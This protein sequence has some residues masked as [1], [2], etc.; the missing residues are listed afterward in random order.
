LKITRVETFSIIVPVH[1]GSW[2]SPEYLPEG[3]TYGG[4]FIRLNWPEFPIVL[5]KLHTDEGLVGLGEVPKG[6]LEADVRRHAMF[7]EGRNLWS[8]NLQELPFDAMWFD[9][10]SAMCGYEMALFDLMGKALD[11]PAYR[12][13]GGKYRDLVPVSRCSGR[14]SPEHAAK[15]ANEA[16]AQGYSVLKMKATADDD[17]ASRLEAIQDA[18]GDKLSIVI[19]PNQRFYTPATLFEREEELRARG[20]ANVQCFESPY[21]QTNLDWY[22]LARN[23]LTTPI[24]L[25]IESPSEI[26]EAI[27][28]EACDWINTGGPMMNC[29]KTA[30]MCAAAGIPTWHGSGVDL[31]IAEAAHTHAAAACESMTLTSD[32][33]G[34]TLRVDDL[35]TEPLVIE[36][37]HV[38][39]PEGPGLGITLDEDA[40]ERYRMRE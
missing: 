7:F 33:C 1:E 11:I 26:R 28:R 5:L 36:N 4:A 29:F 34:E 32:I 31:G 2:H 10:T 30:A 16:V 22:V 35:I 38:R 18:V 12:L 40:L 27:K 9:H 19:D 39:V 25:H 3:K 8:F 15:T 23:R 13:L 14:M 17:I 20:I 37:G 24:A 21:D 6:V